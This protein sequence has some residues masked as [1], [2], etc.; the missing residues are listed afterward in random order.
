MVG[1]VYNIDFLKLIKLSIPTFWRTTKRL[2]FLN[3]ILTPVKSH[4]NAFVAYKND[5]I[6]RVSHNGSITL[7]QKVL[8]DKFDNLDRRIFI[9][10][11][12]RRNG[13]RFYPEAANREVG[14]YSPA[15]IA[16]R[17][18]LNNVNGA[19]FIIN[20]PIEYQYGDEVQLNKFLIKLRAQ[21]DY[22]KLYAKKYTIVWIE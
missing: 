5:A 20:V 12:Q 15:K 3:T 19:D 2:A 13:I 16:F 4:Y 6:Y 17:P 9:K 11:F 14:F 7:L 18:S 10:N 22:Y 21:V 1:N 8:N